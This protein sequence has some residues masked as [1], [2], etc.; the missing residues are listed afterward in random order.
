MGN[1]VTRV[2]TPI[3]ESDMTAAIANGWQQLF[4]TIPTKEQIALIMAQNALETG[5]RQSMWN[6]NVGNITTSAEGPYNYF[7][8][9]TT[10]EQVSPGQ[11]EKKNLKYRA[12]NTLQEGV[13]DYLKFLSQPGGRYAQAWEHILSPNPESYSKSLK[14][15]GYYTGEEKDYTRI[16]K[17]LFDKYNKSSTFKISPE[18][19]SGQ[20]LNLLP[21]DLNELVKVLDEFNITE[22]NINQ[23]PDSVTDTLDDILNKYI[24]KSNLSNK[25]NY[26]KYLPN[27][28][29][30]IQVKSNSIVDS[31]EFA[32]ILCCALD[33]ELLSSSFIHTNNDIV[34]VECNI[35]GPSKV[36]MDSVSQVTKILS[37]KFAIATKKIG[38][39]QIYTNILNQ[40]SLHS[41][42]T[43]KT[44]ELNH[45]KFLLKFV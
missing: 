24:K 1:R 14:Q 44:S 8:D 34:E 29:I 41:P 36:C 2:Q 27:N 28:T 6:Y 9:L 18:I 38:S 15:S 37:D 20:N 11:W 3:S 31:I 43:L 35:P 22:K 21:E 4:G 5:H 33:E 30:T 13:L 23:L 7:D 19:S 39:V 10:S 42:I 16:L 26:V 25:K 32:N 12:Y 40:K 17:N 45:R